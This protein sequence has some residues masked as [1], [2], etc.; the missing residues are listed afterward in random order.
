MQHLR[1]WC[2]LH[3]EEVAVTMYINAKWSACFVFLHP[4]PGGCVH[5]VQ[6]DTV[7]WE[8]LQNTN[9]KSQCLV[10]PRMEPHGPLSLLPLVA[11]QPALPYIWQASAFKH[12]ALHFH[13]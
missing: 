12:L 2:T 13:T 7:N 1:F 4:F 3:L 9:A 11:S 6:S 10:L 8:V 5:R